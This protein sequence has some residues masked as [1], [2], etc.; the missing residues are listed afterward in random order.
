M[1]VTVYLAGFDGSLKAGI[2]SFI[3]DNWPSVAISGADETSHALPGTKLQA[4]LTIVYGSRLQPRTNLSETIVVNGESTEEVLYLVNAK[5]GR[6]TKSDFI[7]AKDE[8][9]VN[10]SLSRR[11]FLFGVFGRSQPRTDASDVPTVSDDSCEARFGCRKCVDACPAPDA[12]QIQDDSLVLS[13]EH[14][15]RCGICVGVCPVAAI[16]VS[17]MP[18]DAYRGLL[19]AIQRYPAPWKT[20]VI[21]CDEGA[22]PKTPWVDVEQVPEIGLIGLRW[23]AMAASASIGA[24][25]IY[26][27]DG[28]CIGKEHVKRI[29]DLIS[30]VTKTRPPSVYYL[31]GTEAA[32]EIDQINNSFHKREGAA[33]FTANPWKN[34]VNAIANISIEDSQARGLGITDVKVVESCTLCNACVTKCPHSALE[35]VVGDLIFDARECTGCGYCEQVCP[36]HAIALLERAGSAGFERKLIFSDETVRCSKCNTPYAS[37]KMVRKIEA[38]LD[39]NEMKPLCPTCRQMGMYDELLGKTQPIALNQR[40]PTA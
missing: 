21:T 24:T 34:Y 37:I 12:L 25:I 14:C 18:E 16:Q 33:E 9:T 19:S 29:V 5:L 17:E 6:L 36:E 15:V 8:P 28:A 40:S 3:R 30:S 7:T 4:A 38:A 27:P 13:K 2:E 11:E 32:A 31:E 23:L 20:L 39:T 22:V 26:C 35:I 10:S 1:K